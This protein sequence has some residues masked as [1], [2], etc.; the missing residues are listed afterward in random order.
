MHVGY[1]PLFQNP[2][3]KLP[4]GEVYE[5][6][7][8]LAEFADPLGF[9]SIWSIEHHFTDYTM[10][11]DVVQLLS[12][13]AGRYPRL[14][15]GSMVIVLPWHDPIRVAEQISLLDH[16]SGGRMILGL[17]R[18]LGRV[19]Y[20][21]FRIDMDEGR[22]RFVEYAQLVLESLERGYMEGGDSVKQP[23]RD[24]RPFPSRSFRGRTYAAAVSPESMPIMAR[25]GAGLL[26]I[27]Q[28]PWKV[29]KQDF[30]VY[31]RVFREEN[32]TDAPPPLC[33]G[34]YFVDESADR[35]EELANRYIGAYYHT[36]MKHYEMTAE[37]FGKAK[38]Y[39]FYSNVGSYI[40]KHGTEGAAADFV[41]LMPFGTPQQVL[42]KLEYIHN[43]IGMN[44]I[45]CHFSFAGM[46]YDEAERNMRCF[47]SSV[48]PEVKSWNVPP[49]PAVEPLR[50]RV[51]S[52]A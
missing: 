39:E 37:H 17:G 40:D 21:G 43:V 32:G 2:G 22:N 13:M 27:P 49:F 45:M 14:Q 33:G 3:S 41:K 48:L 25:L 29:V 47:A 15:V 28:K 5:N 11:P 50:A 1:A 44:G 31:Q 6:E 16:I 8:R 24:I 42:E 20:D 38:G 34:F 46:P 7:L 35:A 19:E 51:E 36:A 9:D 12:Y 52:A 10:C 26:I 30:D 23:R 18:G 4:D